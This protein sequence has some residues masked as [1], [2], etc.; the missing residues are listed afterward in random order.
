VVSGCGRGDSAR[1]STPRFAPSARRSTE[2]IDAVPSGEARLTGF[3]LDGS[4]TVTSTSGAPVVVLARA[5]SSV[6][7]RTSARTMT[8]TEACGAGNDS[9]SVG[10]Q[11]ANRNVG[12]LTG[13]VSS[14]TG[15]P[16][17]SALRCTSVA[18]YAPG[19]SCASNRTSVGAGACAEAG[20]LTIRLAAAAARIRFMST[21]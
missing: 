5:T 8:C 17:H 4:L 15:C 6:A 1:S 2:A 10:R 16:G 20:A 14:K 11:G 18:V 7:G 3:Q 12:A 13:T 21:S 19:G 9:R